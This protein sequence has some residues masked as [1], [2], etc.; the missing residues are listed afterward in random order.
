M[1][2]NAIIALSIGGII[3]L[4]TI[5]VIL[6]NNQ[7]RP[8]TE[9][10]EAAMMEEKMEET[11]ESMSL[12]TIADIFTRSENVMCTFDVDAEEGTT[13]GT[14]YVAGDNARGEYSTNINDET[15]TGY[16]IRNDDTFYSW[17][18][19]FP[20]G[21]KMVADV[22]EWA[23]NFNEQ[24]EDESVS[25][26]PN[27]QINFKCSAWNVDQSMFE[28]P[29]DVNFITFEGMIGGSEEGPTE[30]GVVDNQTQ[31][32]ICENLSGEARTTCL[33]QLNCN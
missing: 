30:D 22:D 6:W 18:D 8:S 21:V 31:C 16:F 29:A 14:V 32:N 1:S 26:D 3:I 19:Q 15:V 20:T 5:A 9:G 23:E 10:Q 33:E 12:S 2:R 7:T 11:D 4:G 25:F 13:T 24:Q 28:A 27:T 17:T